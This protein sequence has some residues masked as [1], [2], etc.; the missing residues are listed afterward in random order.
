MYAVCV[1]V[2]HS[3]PLVVQRVVTLQAFYCNC[4]TYFRTI[5]CISDLV[6]YDRLVL[7]NYCAG[8]LSVSRE[9]V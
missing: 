8:V 5:G 1:I 6:Y 9:R 4:V 3:V 7:H 2:E